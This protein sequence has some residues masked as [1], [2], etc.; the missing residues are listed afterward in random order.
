MLSEKLQVS[1][2]SLTGEKQE[3]GK[4]SLI[5]VNKVRAVKLLLNYLNVELKDTFA[6]GDAASDIKMVKYCNIGVAKD[7]AADEL[8]EAA[9]Y[10]TNHVNE[11]GLWNAFKEYEVI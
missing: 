8:K 7:N 3:F 1:S 11:D 9:D 10:V 4:F 6:F 5:G 2:W